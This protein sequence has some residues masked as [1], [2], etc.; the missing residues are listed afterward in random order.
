MPLMLERNRSKWF[1]RV[2]QRQLKMNF[3]LKDMGQKE[4]RN[5]GSKEVS[6]AQIKGERT[7]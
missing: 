1:R 7:A 2:N 4:N 6:S 5:S 3:C